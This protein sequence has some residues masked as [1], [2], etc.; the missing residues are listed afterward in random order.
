MVSTAT[1]R[2][3]SSSQR[4]DWPLH[5]PL[6]PRTHPI[7]NRSG[8]ADAAPLLLKLNIPA[9]GLFCTVCTIWVGSSLSGGL[10]QSFAGALKVKIC[11]KYITIW[12]RPGK[13]FSGVLSWSLKI[14]FLKSGGSQPRCL[15]HI[16][17]FIAE[18]YPRLLG[19]TFWDAYIWVET[20]RDI[21]LKMEYNWF[22]KQ[23]QF[24]PYSLSG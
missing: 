8:V 18:H 9:Q 4:G 14:N 23:N 13:L 1:N 21:G 11:N 24:Q 7:E 20:F 16:L 15:T 22:K 17:H 12:G 3:P 10:C 6:Q 19:I 2:R 5:L